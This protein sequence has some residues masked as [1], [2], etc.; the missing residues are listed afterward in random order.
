[1]EIELLFLTS[2]THLFIYTSYT[3][4]LYHI[5]TQIVQYLQKTRY[6]QRE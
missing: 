6:K 5:V 3:I 2:L 1:M 4:V